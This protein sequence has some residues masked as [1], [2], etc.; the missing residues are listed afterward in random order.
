M[1]I[2]DIF[3]NNSNPFTVPDGYFAALHG[4]VMHRIEA[5][6]PKGRIVKMMTFRTLVAAAACILL[7]FSATIWRVAYK[8]K[9]P[10][11]TET[12]MYDDYYQWLYAAR[13]ISEFPE[14]FLIYETDFSE[15][16]EA[17]IDFLERDNVNLIAILNSI[18]N[19]TFFIP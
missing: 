12:V 14:N 10:E 13:D 3:E 4:R 11:M 1:N 17:I 18:E 2:G 19:E 9:Q 16:E 5:E 8:E 7:I 15:E 6:E